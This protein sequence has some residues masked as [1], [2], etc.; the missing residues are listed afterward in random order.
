M[1]NERGAMN[2]EVKTSCFN[3][4]VPRS[5]F[6]VSFPMSALA[7]ALILRRAGKLNAQV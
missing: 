2:A 3:F 4:V 5:A 1:N 7:K 6:N